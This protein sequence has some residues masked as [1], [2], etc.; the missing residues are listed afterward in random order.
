[1]ICLHSLSLL[2]EGTFSY[3]SLL[4]EFIS[5]D[6]RELRTFSVLKAKID[7]SFHERNDQFVERGLNF[8]CLRLSGHLFDSCH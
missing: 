8:L 5:N 2:K 6:F 3:T 1:M 4:N 7:V